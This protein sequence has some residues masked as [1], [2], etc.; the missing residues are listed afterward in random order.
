MIKKYI[1]LMIIFI[2]AFNNSVYAL[3]FEELLEY[4]DKSYKEYSK[5]VLKT[6]EILV[7]EIVDHVGKIELT[8]DE[9][10]ALEKAGINKISYLSYSGAIKSMGGAVGIEKFNADVISKVFNIDVNL[11]TILDIDNRLENSFETALELLEEGRVDLIGKFNYI[12]QYNKDSDIITS[13]PYAK[14][15]LYQIHLNK[16]E[17]GKNIG[18]VHSVD[19]PKYGITKNVSFLNDVNYFDYEVPIIDVT[20]V[21]GML[22]KGEIDYYLTGSYEMDLLSQYK[23]ISVEEHDNT[24]IY[25][26]NVVISHVDSYGDL[27]SAINKIYTPEVLSI[28]DE[29]SD[30]ISSYNRIYSYIK[31]ENRYS[32]IPTLKV[33]VIN[34][35]SFI[36]KKDGE[37]TGY[38][39]EILKELTNKF[40]INFIYEDYTNLGYDKLIEDFN[41]NK[42]D[43]VPFITESL[44]KENSWNLNYEEI[45][46]LDF[47]H[48]AGLEIF[49]KK[50]DPLKNYEQ[51]P[52]RKIGVYS[53]TKSLVYQYIES[54]LQDYDNVVIYYDMEVMFNDLIEGKID[55]IYELEGTE[56][57]IKD[58]NS[59]VYNTLNVD[60]EGNYLG[61]IKNRVLDDGEYLHSKLTDLINLVNINEIDDRELQFDINEVYIEETSMYINIWLSALMFIVIASVII[62]YILYRSNINSRRTLQST[63]RTY[64]DTVFYNR[65]AFIDDVIRSE[66][67]NLICSFVYI[68]NTNKLNDYY[69]AE[70][71]NQIFNEFITRLSNIQN[72]E[73]FKIYFL[74]ESEFIITSS[75][76]N[77]EKYNKF[78]KNIVAVLNMPYYIDDLEEKLHFNIIVINT[79][80]LKNN[81]DSLLYFNYF[82][83]NIEEN[84]ESI[85]ITY[86]KK[87]KQIAFNRYSEI[88]KILTIENIMNYI[89]LKFRPIIDIESN[90]I[91]GAQVGVYLVI[92]GVM[93]GI[94]DYHAPA[95]MSNKMPIIEFEAVN[96][97][98][99]IRETFYEQGLIDESFIFSLPVS[100]ETIL[101]H[102]VLRDGTATTPSYFTFEGVQLEI[103]EEIL[104]SDEFKK[105]LNLIGKYN[106][107]LA[108]TEFSAGH[109][110]ME[111][112]DKIDLENIILNTAFMENNSSIKISRKIKEFIES[113][114]YKVMYNKVTS[115]EQ[116]E[117][118][119]QFGVKYVV[120]DYSYEYYSLLDFKELVRRN[121]KGL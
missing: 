115:E 38:I 8:Y 118:L 21:Y 43:I 107:K 46:I 48:G 76:N 44:Y 11:V 36:E 109:S 112:L 35:P 105:F 19:E 119:K 18:T 77:K 78:L 64:K 106:F 34:V 28:Y 55:L 69:G 26:N 9:A 103:N 57:Y 41:D 117:T 56:K 47:K 12:G 102:N 40:G 67:K 121:N 86:L 33:G 65:T 75:K 97:M 81:E 6:H 99:K 27:I 15:F 51:L 49:Y 20:D 108:I 66:D 29:Y 113:I 72:D 3:D 85:L 42:I 37:W 96:K 62:F 13:E 14:D 4:D 84:Q 82:V 17:M 32:N 24:K 5:E 68:K 16:I 7:D 60:I 61:L 70:K 39:I 71:F 22:E 30:I 31:K 59:Y 10:L 100:S 88:I 45:G 2:L 87:D 104:E 52:L 23:N 63:I 25:P 54:Y 50:D 94:E 74:D 98:K 58:K 120:G 114:G 1:Y 93:V 90:K 95:K 110:S 92:N 83:K 80:D 91:I 101:N 53:L 79:S 116:R 111:K 73:E 89:R